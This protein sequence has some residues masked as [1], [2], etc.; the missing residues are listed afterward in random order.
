MQI[1]F[2][3]VKDI[4]ATEEGT[5]NVIAGITKKIG[6]EKIFNEK[7]TLEK[8]RK[9]D[10]SYGQQANIMIANIATGYNPLYRLQEKYENI[11]LEGVFDEEIN[12]EQLT[13]DRFAQFLDRFWESNPKKIFSILS[14]E[15][16]KHYGINITTVNFDTTSKIMWGKYQ[17]SDGTIGTI[18]ITYGHSKQKRPDKNQIKMGIGTANGIIVDA[19]VISGNTDDKT[20]NT[21]KIKEIDTL[22]ERTNT[23]KNNFYYIADSAAFTKTTVQEAKSREINL[24]SRIPDSYKIAKTLTEVAL[25]EEEKWEIIEL[26]TSNKKT[27]KYKII[28]FEDKKYQG[29]PCN[30]VVCYSEALKETKEK[31]IIKKVKK[32]AEY[33]EKQLKKYKTRQFA[34]QEDAEKE[35]KEYTK[36]QVIKQK[37]HK[38]ELNITEIQKR[39]QGRPSKKDLTKNTE[40]EYQIEWE[41]KE[42]KQIIKKELKKSCMFLLATTDMKMKGK[43][44]LVEYKTQGAVEKK[45]QQIKS[46]QFVSSLFITTPKRV[47]AITYMILIT[48]MILSVME[49]VVRRE[50]KKE[51]L[52]IIGPGKVK[53]KTPSLVAILRIFEKILIQTITY[54]NGEIQR[55]LQKPLTKSQE[56]ILKCLNLSKE[57]YETPEV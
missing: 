56:I 22:L 33:L 37:Y 29:V 13:D 24:I 40:I 5:M 53:M 39:K 41:I 34:C 42:D 45:F 31:S 20:Y 35:I 23:S 16:L 49:Y 27:N 43:E 30:T 57:I 4:A 36:K 52:E 25:K 50:M 46:P 3:N 18:D 10:I 2:K 21:D 19:D 15:I 17:A 8:G 32:E 44:I 9:S 28:G 26:K 14:T 51:D 1:D 6:L 55:K 54:N 12:I 7:L 48:M 38:I 47:E 11:D